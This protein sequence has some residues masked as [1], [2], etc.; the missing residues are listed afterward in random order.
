M[1]IGENP[2]LFNDYKQFN[3][4]RKQ[5]NFFDFMKQKNRNTNIPQSFPGS[6]N[7]CDFQGGVLS[8]TRRMH[9]QCLT[10]ENDTDIMKS[11]N[12]NVYVQIIP[13]KLQK[14]RHGG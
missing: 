8:L 4:Y 9:I 12:V 11:D 2:V 7:L 14:G 6:L 13:T 3:D 1:I 5:L 10:V